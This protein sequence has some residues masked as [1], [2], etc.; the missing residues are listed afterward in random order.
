MGK[1]ST[2][3]DLGYLDRPLKLSTIHD[4]C[5]GAGVTCVGIGS[6]LIRK[7]LVAAGDWDGIAA[8]VH[9]VLQWI[10]GVR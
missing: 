2:V 6:K 5:I 10:R 3:V 4:L 8:N 9:Q 1:L 7:D